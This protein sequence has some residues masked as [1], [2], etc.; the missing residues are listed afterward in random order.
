MSLSW[1]FTT[2]SILFKVMLCCSVN[3]LTFF[4]WT[5]LVLEVV[6]TAH[7]F[8]TNWQL[9]FLNHRSR[10]FE[11]GWGEWR[12]G[13]RND[14]MINH[15]NSYVAKFQ[16]VTPGSAVRW[17]SACTME[18]SVS[19]H[20]QTVNAQITGWL[21]TAECITGFTCAWIHLFGITDERSIQIITEELFR[22]S[23]WG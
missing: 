7:T 18:P 2:Q 8:S 6:N 22:R 21:N 19:G 3:L 10:G 5:G 23:I 15:H 12:N 14:F 20:M 1:S 16:F 13:H 11:G 9:S 17:A 4:S